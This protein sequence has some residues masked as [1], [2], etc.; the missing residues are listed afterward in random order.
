MHEMKTYSTFS[1]ARM[2][3]VDPGSVANWVDQGLL[4]AH[5]TP[6]KHRRVQEADLLDFLQRQQMPIPP[7]LGQSDIRR[8]LV[9]D[10]DRTVV[11]SVRRA[12]QKAGRPCEVLDAPT[13]FRAGALLAECKPN[14]VILDLKMP[15]LDAFDIC[16]L[17]KSQPQ[18]SSI[19]IVAVSPRADHGTNQK[20]ILQCGASACLS[21]PLDLALLT[22]EIEPL[23][24]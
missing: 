19:H 22:K 24:Q 18:T 3:Q 20:E 1:I 8:V 17:L 12:M 9:I 6:G 2:L 14:V 13:A 5:R 7:Q 4:K 21:R 10:S 15:G 23:L 11:E 16:R